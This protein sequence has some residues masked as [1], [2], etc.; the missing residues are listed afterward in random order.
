MASRKSSLL[1]VRT[2]T[3]IARK[4]PAA[5]KPQQW[6]LQ[7]VRSMSNLPE[8][9]VYG[10]PQSRSPWKRITLRHLGLKYEKKQAITV[11]TA[12]D[13]PSAVHVDEA[14]IDICLVG[15]SVGMVVHGHDTTLPV[16]MADMLLHCRAV[17]RG[18]NRPL[19]V[20]DLP[21]GSYEQ[22]AQQAVE[23]AT[24]LLKEGGMDAV[25]MEGGGGSRVAAAKAIAEAGIAVMGHVGLTPQAI[26]VMGGFRPQGRS[27]ESALQVLEHAL[28]LQAVGCFSI[29]L[30]CIPSPIAAAVTSALHI[31]TIGIGA[32]P[33][34]SGQVLVYHDLLGMM[35]HPHHAKVTPKF[36]KQ[37]ASVGSIIQAA[38]S[39]YREEVSSQAF[40]SAMHT[41]YRIDKAQTNAFLNELEKRGF[42][43]AAEAA[44]EAAQTCNITNN[45]QD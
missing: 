35:Q 3:E 21:F 9:T 32:G 45:R 18:A 15:D 31:P 4:T 29:V 16:T 17:A 8:S 12:Y 5:T 42:H 26:S 39:E 20:G 11:V 33:F 34:C 44:S 27:A 23:S 1:L 10:G 25:K 28:A 40:P 2:I 13:Y 22:S 30:E 7:Q 41:P 43:E 36:C 24:R 37:Y 14:G 38:L 19:L 6:V